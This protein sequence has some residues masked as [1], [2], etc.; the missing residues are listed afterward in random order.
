MVSVAITSTNGLNAGLHIQLFIMSFIN[1]NVLYLRAGNVWE[2]P[3]TY[4]SLGLVFNVIT[5]AWK[6]KVSTSPLLSPS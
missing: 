2:I 1:G 4:E 3:T 6:A 5:I